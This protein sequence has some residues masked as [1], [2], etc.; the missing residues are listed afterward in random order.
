MK[1]IPTAEGQTAATSELPRSLLLTM[2]TAAAVAVSSIYYNQPLL[3]D[4]ARELRVDAHHIGYVATATQ[5]G[6]AAGMPVFLP[7]G[8]IVDRRNLVTFLFLAAA[9]ALSF[10]ALSKG[11]AALV[12]ASF[13]LGLTSVIAQVLIPFAADLA[14][15]AQQGRT[16]G[17]ILSG[18]LLGILLAR[19]VS[20]IVAAHAGWRTMYWIA[21]AIAV[22]FAA[23]LRGRLP[24]APPH[25]RDSY[26]VIMRSL[27]QLV[28]GEP[29]LRQVCV[30]AAMFFGSFS[31]F[32][33]TLIFLL[34]RPPYHYG[35]QTAGLFGL[36]GA[37][38]ALVAPMAGRL[39]D[40]HSPR[41]VVRI[42]IALVTL[43]FAMFWI[44]GLSIWGLVLGVI[45]LDAGVQ[46]AQVANQSR[47][48]SLRPQLRS[49]INT[50]YMIVYFG[51]GSLGSFA[52]ALVWTHYGWPGVCGVGLTMMLIATAVLWR[53]P[54][55]QPAA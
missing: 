8:D 35:S 41:Y 26:G 24:S 31:A 36:I 39:S 4:M 55:Q 27:G 1:A 42:A 48:L 54:V 13:L 30:I 34:E 23:V 46:A 29:V 22:A 17:T 47:V 7:L 32:W 12:L 37:V 43:S 14:K 6:Y 21:A 11:L 15:P 51:G 52:G 38:G 18:V 40:K 16:I 2:A 25:G 28:L 5:I 44:L 45:V 19:T 9:L 3:G 53:L 33:T 20:G 10:V 49:R 50:I